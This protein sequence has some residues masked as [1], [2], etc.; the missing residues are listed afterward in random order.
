M[1]TP[2]SADCCSVAAGFAWS[3][4]VSN[5]G[6][7]SKYAAFGLGFDLPGKVLP[8]GVSV[9]VT[10]GVGYSWFGDQSSALG[11]FALPAYVNWNAGMTFPHKRLNLDLRYY[12]TNLSKENYFVFTGD[13][14]ATPAGQPDPLTNPDGLVSSWWR[15]TFVAKFSF[16]LN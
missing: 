1:P 10:G 9:S 15:A 2:R 6:A 12:D 11:G 14:D 5:T 13:L 3:P 16:S 7:W 4:N 8:Q